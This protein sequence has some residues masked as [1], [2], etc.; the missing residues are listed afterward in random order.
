MKPRS[1]SPHPEQAL[2]KKVAAGI[3]APRV[4]VT[5]EP[6]LADFADARTTAQPRPNETP[7][8]LERIRLL[9]VV[10]SEDGVFDRFSALAA[11][12]LRVPLALVSLVKRD[13]QV[14]K[15]ME[16]TLPEPW[17]SRRSTPLSHSFCQYVQISREVL[18]VSDAR[19]H[20]LV[21]DNLAV[22]ELGVIA[23]LGVPLT[24]A[25]GYTLGSFC[26]IDH[27]PREWTAEEVGILQGIASLVM[28][29]IELRLGRDQLLNR[30][31][32]LQADESRR[33][34]RTRLLVHDLRT[35]LNSLLLG[36]KTLPMLGDLNEDQTESLQLALRGGK[37][38]V[39][40]VDDLLDAEAAEEGG[41]ASLRITA[42]LDP[43]QLMAQ[44]VAQVAA[45]AANRGVTL[46]IEAR[47]NEAGE[48]LSTTFDADADKTVRALVN[49][50]SNAVKFTP[51]GGQVKIAARPGL[52]ADG[53][54][55]VF[56]V[57]DTG[58]GIA[59]EDLQRVFERYV[60]LGSVEPGAQR[61]SGLGLS[62]VKA[63]AE[64]H[65]GRTDVESTPGQ[66]SVFRLIFPRRQPLSSRG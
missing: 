64:A 50:L 30:F 46:S 20:P 17:Q 53:K 65:G 22:T 59:R 2:T 6:P 24:T 45:L 43:A 11:R 61:S 7:E 36:L 33:N 3:I 28:I 47:M 15:G 41:A 27:Q 35:P 49:L 40:L 52:W 51:V 39:Q 4:T 10:T 12:T 14:F 25:D 55:A 44:A 62:F 38:L 5:R 56:S 34:E 29:E 37:T 16:G 21:R 63:V 48:P 8:V 13:A 54:C 42:D 60:H 23:Y 9:E 18:L 31:T 32:A 66:G 19:N 1:P 57:R 26:A 58:R